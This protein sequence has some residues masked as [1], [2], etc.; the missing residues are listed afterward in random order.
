MDDFERDFDLRKNSEVK[1]MVD[2]KN[3]PKVE[4]LKKDMVEAS[5]DHD[6][7]VDRVQSWVDL[8]HVEGQA[9]LKKRE[10]FSAY[11]PK[12]IRKQA[13]WRYGSLSDPFLVTEDFITCEPVTAEDRV[14]AYQN[15]LILNTQFRRNFNKTKFIDEYV[16]TAV[17]EGTVILKTGWLYTD[18]IISKTVPIY[19]FELDNSLPN[20]VAMDKL[21]KMYNEDPDTFYKVVPKEYIQAFEFTMEDPEGNAYKPVIVDEEEVDDIRILQ[22]HPTVEIC[23]IEDV[24]VDPTCYGDIAKAK[25]VV[26]RFETCYADLKK[27]GIYQNLDIL[28]EMSLAPPEETRINSSMLKNTSSFRFQDEPRKRFDAYEYWGMWDINDDGIL[29]PI[30]AVFVQDLMILLS[31]NPFPHQKIP[32]IF[33]PYLPVK[34][35]CYGEPDAIL[36][37][38]NQHIMGAVS[39]GMVD[40]LARSANGQTGISKDALDMINRRRFDRGLDYEFNPGRSP[41]EMF[42]MHQYPEIPASAFNL[43][44]L[45]SLEAESMTGIKAFTGGL[46]GDSL[47]KTSAKGVQGVLDA[48]SIREAGILRRL[49]KGITDVCY[50]WTAMNKELLSDE[51]IIRITNDQF[52]TIKRDDLDSKIDIKVKITSVQENNQ[53]AQE[54]AFMLQTIGP[55]SDPGEVRLIRAEIAR[56]RNMPEL[57]K[58]IEEYRPQPDPMQ[59][60]LAQLEIMK[61]QKELGLIDAETLERQAGAML[62]QAKAANLQ[63]DTDLKN[64]DFVEQESGTKHARDV[65]KVTSQAKAQTMK[66]IV[67][68]QLPKPEKAA[69]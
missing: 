62:D 25:F 12:V 9:K 27:E 63:S 24:I 50:H 61:L 41:A 21:S 43:L 60:M 57:A 65:D 35:S 31:K 39:R 32:F 38:D 11:Q 26:Y 36:I 30:R 34:E 45:N 33:V 28:A 48:A 59:Q 5:T 4:D 17:D 22:N 18:T 51:E 37:E 42:F 8:L 64:L 46:S 3:P 53:K 15:Q 2:W 29:V 40:L 16:R 58:K 23:N 6:A 20:K 1:D 69:P 54:L 47:G 10:G 49:A 55:N 7:Q 19:D 44:Q 66:S 56:L 67:E 14:G 13:E 68:S 52:V